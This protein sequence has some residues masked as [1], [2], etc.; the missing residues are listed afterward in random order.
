MNRSMIAIAI[1]IIMLLAGC[2][3]QAH[4]I[5]DKRRPPAKSQTTAVSSTPSIT[6]VP[7]C[8]SAQ[9]SATDSGNQG[10]GTQIQT[11]I[12]ITNIGGSACVLSGVPTAMDL[13]GGGTT[14]ATKTLAVSSDLE[15]NAQLLRPH[16][17]DAAYL[18]VWWGNWCGSANEQA[19]LRVTLPDAGG[20][21]VLTPFNTYGGHTFVPACL[22]Q[23]EPST[24]QVT[25]AYLSQQ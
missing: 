22:Q 9:L 10:G 7:P 12:K 4:H 14:L 1:G 16:A 2:G 6:A 5:T 21:P 23:G 20:P 11:Y 18:V 19:E 15:Q 25:A 24:L 3:T 13:L 8:T 17:A